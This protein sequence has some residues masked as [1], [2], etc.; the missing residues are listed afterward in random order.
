RAVALGVLLWAQALSCAYYGI[1]AGLMVGLGA[2]W[3][4]IS[5]RRWTSADYW[6]GIGLAA[7]VCIGLTLPF[8]L[9]YLEVQQEQG[10]G[11]TL[12]DAR[13]YSANVG[14]WFASA[15]WAH[16]WWLP[17]LGSFSEVLFPGIAATVLGS[18]GLWLALRRRPEQAGGS[19]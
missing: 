19:E 12:D 16:R 10:F 9:P 7:F 11:R 13:Q 3:F 1:F 6:V 15:A 18:V 14:A 8:F 17:G 2:V 4:A 5:R